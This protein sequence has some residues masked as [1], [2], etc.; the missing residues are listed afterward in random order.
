M[1]L[2][3][4]KLTI[5]EG[6]LIKLNLIL[7]FVYSIICYSIGS[8]D[9]IINQGRS[10]VTA[11]A[12]IHVEM[13]TMGCEAVWSLNEWL[14]SPFDV[15]RSSSGSLTNSSTSTSHWNL[16]FDESLRQNIFPD[17]S[18]LSKHQMGSSSGTVNW[19][20]RERW[21]INHK[22]E[23]LIHHQPSLLRID[24]S[25]PPWRKILTQK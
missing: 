20:G 16:T 8:L 17:T 3:R 2:F 25:R 10:T 11:M 18:S 6:H 23:T 5:T 19:Y 1:Y 15:K 21:N 13:T 4:L 12:Q 9:P 7:V 24:Y 22:N 14:N